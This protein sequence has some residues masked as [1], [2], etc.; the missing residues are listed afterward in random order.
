MKKLLLAVVAVALISGAAFAMDGENG[1]IKGKV[2]VQL[3]Q[4]LSNGGSVDLD[5]GFSI[6]VEYLYPVHEMV[7]AG[8]GVEYMFDR[9]IEDTSVKVSQIPVYLTAEVAPIETLKEL[10]FKANLGWAFAKIKDG[11][12]S[13]S[14]SGFLWA[15]GAGYNL[16]YNIVIEATYGMTYPSDVTYKALGINVGYRFGL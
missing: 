15:V 4:S 10:Y 11:G 12:A 8:L 13:D 14:D 16:P 6:G 5:T 3:L 1:E 9:K 7:K 2:G